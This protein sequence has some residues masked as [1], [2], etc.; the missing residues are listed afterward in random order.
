MYICSVCPYETERR[1]LF[2]RHEKGKKHKEN[3]NKNTEHKLKIINENAILNGE[4]VNIGSENVNIPNENVNILNENVNI[5]NENVN[6]VEKGFVCKKCHKSY[7]QKRYL[8]KHEE[9]CK[10]LD[11]LTCANCKKTFSCRQSK[12]IHC[13]KGCKKMV[14]IFEAENVK[15]L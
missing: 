10:G 5:L 2:T 8:N 13:K 9:T 1:D 3:V 11:S 12:S 4:K 15:K 6:I 14:S 7:K